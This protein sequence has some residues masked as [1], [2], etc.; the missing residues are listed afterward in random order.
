[1]SGETN[2]LPKIAVIVSIVRILV[3]L[4][5]F[6]CLIPLPVPGTLQAVLSMTST[7][8]KH[9]GLR[10]PLVDSQICRSDRRPVRASRRSASDLASSITCIDIRAREDNA[11]PTTFGV[12]T[13]FWRTDCPL[14]PSCGVHAII[15]AAMFRR[16]PNAALTLCTQV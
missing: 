8:V 4:R 3:I 7:F 1:M 14:C 6:W 15:V 13:D 12:S 11:L 16:L 9:E 2:R 5:L 10:F